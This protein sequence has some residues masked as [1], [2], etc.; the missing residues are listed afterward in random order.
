MWQLLQW[1]TL[2]FLLGLQ[3]TRVLEVWLWF[4]GCSAGHVY[5]SHTIC[6]V[7]SE[8]T[9]RERNVMNTT[10]C[11]VRER[12]EVQHYIAPL[13]SWAWWRAAIELKD[14]CGGA[15]LYVHAGP[16]ICHHRSSAIKAWIEVSSVRLCGGLISHTICAIPCS[17]PSVNRGHI[18][19][20]SFILACTTLQSAPHSGP[21]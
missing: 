1:L 12:N 13:H 6:V 2:S 14:E 10:Y 9:E 15:H 7:P 3:Y 18:H 17:S 21:V 20:I 16:H 5:M 8:L 4:G 19:N 11:S